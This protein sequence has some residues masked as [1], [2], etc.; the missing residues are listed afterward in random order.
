M[1]IERASYKKNALAVLALASVLMLV[2]SPFSSVNAESTLLGN[3]EYE[4]FVHTHLN[5]PQ[6]NFTVVDKPVFP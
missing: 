6:G 3:S 1:T 2:F 4:Q 5:S